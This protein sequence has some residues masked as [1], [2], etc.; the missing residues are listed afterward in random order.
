MT[1]TPSQTSPLIVEQHGAVRRLRMNRPAALNALNLDLIEALAA[2]IEEAL[3]DDRVTT[4]WLESTS[5]RSFC[6]GGDVKALAQVLRDASADEQRRT[7]HR[8]FLAEYRLDALIAHC[9][10]PIVAWGQGLVMGGGWGLLAG[11]DLRLVTVDARFAMP[12]IQIGLFPDVGAAHFLQQPDWRLGT[13]LGISGVHI[14]GREAVALG[15]ADAVMTPDTVE[16]LFNVLAEGQPLEEWQRP[17]PDADTQSLAT[18]WNEALD[19]LPAPVLADWIDHINQYDF[20]AFNEAA[21]QWQRG[22]ALSMALTWHHFKRLRQASRVEALEM[23]LIVGAQACSEREF[24]EGVRALLIDK[25]KSPVWLYP[26]TT[27]VPFTMI[28]RFYRPL[29]FEAGVI[30]P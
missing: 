15:Y 8:Y 7:G 1:E 16:P 3:D 11:A 18:A 17:E 28:E 21:E 20:K 23:D 13:F 5:E 10:K 19:S 9:P 12:E 24:L 22:S 4:L 14:S 6:A 29:P 27:A 2:A 30:W 26:N 25:D